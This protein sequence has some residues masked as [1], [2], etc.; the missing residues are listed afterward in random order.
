MPFSNQWKAF[1]R[2]GALAGQLVSSGLTQLRKANYAE[3]GRYSEAFFNLSQG[4]ERTL[5]LILLLDHAI[6][7]GGQF[8]TEKELRDFGH[9]L[10]QLFAH[11]EGIAARLELSRF[12]ANSIERSVVRVLST[13]A[14]TTRYYNLDFLVGGKRAQGQQDPI[15][16]WWSDVAQP[17][18]TKHYSEKRRAADVERAH[19]MANGLAGAALVLHTAEDGTVL[20]DFANASAHTGKI[21]VV[22]KYGTFYAVSVCRLLYLILFELVHEAHSKQLDVPTLY[23][24]YFPFMNEDRYL[25]GLKTFPPRGQ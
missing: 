12:P 17:I 20:A 21:A 2:E 6:R 22:Q 4:M 3:K 7:K 11:A 14:V 13:F 25:L 15:A 9:D 5:K 8:P 10:E 16:L 19:T 18:L 23:E 24:Y 1:A